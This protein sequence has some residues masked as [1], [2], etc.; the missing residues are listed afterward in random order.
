MQPRPPRKPTPSMETTLL[1]LREALDSWQA[2][3]ST[4]NH[5]SADKTVSPL[6]S[7]QWIEETQALLK[8]LN[9]Q[10]NELS[11]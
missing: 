1:R 11:R 10:L 6:L 4:P 5:N 7:D 9:R 3:G 8:T 2:V